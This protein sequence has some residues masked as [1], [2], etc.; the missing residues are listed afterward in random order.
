MIPTNTCPCFPCVSRAK[1]I[2][3]VRHDNTRNRDLSGSSKAQ[4]CGEADLDSKGL[5]DENIL[6]TRKDTYPA[7]HCPT[8]VQQEN[9]FGWSLWGKG[10]FFI[11][12]VQGP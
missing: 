9:S 3:T 10:V 8:G 6:S 11:A 5:E 4:P 1:Q 12:R 2:F 7:E